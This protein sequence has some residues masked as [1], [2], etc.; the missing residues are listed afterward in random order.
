MQAKSQSSQEGNQIR[1]EGQEIT[2]FR[3]AIWEQQCP[4]PTRGGRKRWQPRGTWCGR[5]RS[6]WNWTCLDWSTWSRFATATIWTQLFKCT[7]IIWSCTGG[8]GG[9]STTSCS[10]EKSNGVLLSSQRRE[11]NGCPLG[12]PGLTQPYSVACVSVSAC[13]GFDVTSMSMSLVS[14]RYSY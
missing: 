1:P 10:M 2:S 9:W 8:T 3:T 5:G 13:F 14:S 6:W 12:C 4:S 11:R 7:R